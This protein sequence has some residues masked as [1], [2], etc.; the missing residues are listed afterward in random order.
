MFFCGRSL[1]GGRKIPLTASLTLAMMFVSLFFLTIS[2][3][4]PILPAYVRSFTVQD[5]DCYLNQLTLMDE[6]RLAGLYSLEGW[7]I[8]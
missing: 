2:G 6:T 7:T 8:W 1:G 5:R 3:E 4:N